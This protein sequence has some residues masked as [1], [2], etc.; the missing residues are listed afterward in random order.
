[1]KAASSKLPTTKS[2]IATVASLEQPPGKPPILAKS[3][4]KIQPVQRLCI[5]ANILKEVV[6]KK[7]QE[8]KGQIGRKVPIEIEA[9]IEF[10]LSL[11]PKQAGIMQNKQ[12]PI[13]SE[14]FLT[15]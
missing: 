5:T 12:A 15:F 9:V 8:C 13:E 3:I 2:P 10:L 4:P 6:K 11:V 14:K 7:K 1:M